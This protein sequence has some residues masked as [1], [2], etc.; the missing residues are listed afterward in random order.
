MLIKRQADRLQKGVTNIMKYRTITEVFD[1]GPYISKI[2]LDTE[3]ELKG[4]HLST[5]LFSV[6]ARQ[7]SVQED[8]E[9]PLFM[10]KPLNEQMEGTRKITG[11]YLS[12]SEGS[13]SDSGTYLTLCLYCDPREGYGSIV[14]FNGQF[15]VFVNTSYTITQTAP[16]LTPTE[17]IKNMEFTESCGNRI[18]YGE[19][20]KT[21]TFSHPSLSLSYVYYEPEQEQDEQIP[22]LIWLHGA[23]EGG[24]E[25]LIAAIGNKV[26]NLI[27]PEIQKIFGKSYLLAPQCPTM[28]MDDG[29]GEYTQ[30]G[31]SKYTATVDELI[32]TFLDSHPSI[33]RTRV[34]L[35][36][37]SNG[38]F[39]TMKLLQY[40]ESP[41]A[42][43]FPVCEA[44]DD[45]ALSDDD[46]HRLKNVPIWFTHAKNDPVVDPERYVLATY[47]RL[48][49][50]GAANV[51]FTFWDRIEDT[52]GLA[53]EADGSPYQYSGHW[54]WIPMLNNQ[55][56]LDFDGQPVTI[57][58][59]PVSLL[60][61]LAAQKRTS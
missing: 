40:D 13:P 34:Y 38:G 24:A 29:T 12:D 20:L 42:A 59:K 36:G 60:E 32:R 8:F 21:G 50:A 14:R 28:W 61:W 52:T 1:F 18:L 7:S 3:H 49:A 46:I 11:L 9:W 19:L 23:G 31:S 54:A 27:S 26:V 55:C 6:Y 4:A 39:M 33:D 44:L 43:A 2:I 57:N 53:P 41:Y 10:G 17:T 35:G 48:M 56:R 16:I 22:L 30:D 51:H 47:K 45:R 5:N 37:D 58:G 15:N 25:P